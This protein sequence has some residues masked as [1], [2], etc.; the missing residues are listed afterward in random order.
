MKSSGQDFGDI[1]M[2]KDTLQAGSACMESV[3]GRELVFS[4]DSV[5]IFVDNIPFSSD[6]ASYCHDQ[7]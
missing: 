5:S 3:L 7:K 2:A 4:V 1:S 6:L